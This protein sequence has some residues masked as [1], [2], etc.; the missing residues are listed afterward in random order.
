MGQN[1]NYKITGVGPEMYDN[2]IDIEGYN[3]LCRDRNIRGIG[4]ML[5][6]K[7]KLKAKVIWTSKTEHAKKPLKPDYIF[8]S[9][10]ES[11]SSPTLLV[12]VY[13]PPD[14]PIRSDMHWSTSRSRN[15][16]S[17]H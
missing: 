12:L 10:W 7:D 3:I 8:C 5:Y 15:P 9:I 2:I 13:H 6:I 1:Y 17:I 4:V 16:S 14:V 11:N